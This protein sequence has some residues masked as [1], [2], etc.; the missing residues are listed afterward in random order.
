MAL[1]D[2]NQVRNEVERLDGEANSGIEHGLDA[3]CGEQSKRNAD[4][5][6]ISKGRDFSNWNRELRDQIDPDTKERILL[7]TKTQ[8]QKHLKKLLK[9]F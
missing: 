2:Y 9:D 1:Q 8:L 6:E 7:I 5:G 3:D 4:G